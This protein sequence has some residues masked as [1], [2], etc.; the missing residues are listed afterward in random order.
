[1]SGNVVFVKILINLHSRK[2][3]WFVNKRGLAIA[4]SV[5]HLIVFVIPGKTSKGHV[6]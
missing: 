5:V 1:M 4:R 6:L 2:S 3:G